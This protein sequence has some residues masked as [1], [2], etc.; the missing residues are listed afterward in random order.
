MIWPGWLAGRP[1]AAAAAAG[2]AGMPL[3]LPPV[4]ICI[5]FCLASAA[6][7]ASVCLHS[8]MLHA[9]SHTRTH[10]ALGR[11]VCPSPRPHS[12]LGSSSLGGGK[13]RRR[14]CTGCGRRRTPPLSAPLSEFPVARDPC[15]SP[16]RAEE[17]RKGRGKERYLY[18]GSCG[19]GAGERE[20][21]R[22]VGLGRQ[23]TLVG[24]RRCRRRLRDS[25]ES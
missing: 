3:S 1:S 12:L 13:R 5:S 19:K 24:F 4:F 8:W 16:C 6:A 21:K 17:G 11:P 20:R 14:R 18:F 2:N 10:L 25:S 23:F 7:A 22:I 9:R 15:R